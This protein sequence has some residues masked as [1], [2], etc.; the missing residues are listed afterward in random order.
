MAEL[1]T[2]AEAAG[3]LRKSQRWLRDWLKRHP[4]DADGRPF[5]AKAGRTL[6]FTEVDIDHIH[7][8]L[9]PP[10]ASHRGPPAGRSIRPAAPSSIDTW[11]EVAKLLGDPSLARGLPSKPAATRSPR[12]SCKGTARAAPVKPRP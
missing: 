3:Q 8:A 1:F 4:H 7:E 5:F 10:R 9:R 11:A 12:I 2:I 6:L